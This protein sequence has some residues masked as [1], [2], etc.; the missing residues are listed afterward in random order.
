MAISPA[1]QD[2]EKSKFVESPTR[3][4][5][6]ATEIVD[7]TKGLLFFYDEVD[8]STTYLGWA[9]PGSLESNLVWRIRKITLVSTVRKFQWAGGSPDFVN[10]WDNRYSLT[11][12]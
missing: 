4:S 8:A 7:G 6:A 10:S 12:S 3:A 11:Y 5:S 2:N 9:Q 1:T